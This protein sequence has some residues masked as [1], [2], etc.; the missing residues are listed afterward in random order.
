MGAGYFIPGRLY[1][2]LD[3]ISPRCPA[4]YKAVRRAGTAADSI[5]QNIGREQRQELFGDLVSSLSRGANIFAGLL[6]PEKASF[7]NTSIPAADG[8]GSAFWISM[9]ALLIGASFSFSAPTSFSW[10][11]FHFLGD[12]KPQYSAKILTRLPFYHVRDSEE[13][14]RVHLDLD[15]HVPLISE[16]LFSVNYEEIPFAPE[17]AGDRYYRCLGAMLSSISRTKV[18]E[19]MDIFSTFNKGPELLRILSGFTEI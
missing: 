7:L 8:K 18:S 5:A 11:Y 12:L 9:S 19:I 10:Y 17:S 16:G 14:A 3:I 2:E 6:D 1:G 13:A 4:L 15:L